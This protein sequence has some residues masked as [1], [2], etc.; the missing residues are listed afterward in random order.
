MAPGTRWPLA[1]V[2]DRA[3]LET[4]RPVFVANAAKDPA[5]RELAFFHDHGFQ[6]YAGVPRSDG[7]VAIMS[8]RPLA[9]SPQDLLL[10]ALHS[11]ALPGE[12]SAVL[13]PASGALT[14][15]F[16]LELTAAELAAGRQTGLLV[17]RSTRLGDV[18]RD[19]GEAVADR[20]LSQLCVL[21]RS[22][23]R[24]TAPVGRL[25]NDALG[26][27]LVDVSLRD[28]Q[29]A[30]ERLAREVRESSR[31][32]TA[33]GLAHGEGLAGGAEALADLGL[34]AAEESRATGARSVPTRLSTGSVP[35][36]V[37]PPSAGP[38]AD[39]ALAARYQRLALLNRMS[40]ELF[41][42]KPFA[43]ALTGACHTALALTGARSV[44]V[45]FADE[46][47]SPSLAY[48]HG[49][50]AFSEETSRAEERSL[51][52]EAFAE[53]RL[54]SRDAA[55]RHWSAAPLMRITP[56]AVSVT[57]AA[58]FGYDR[59]PSEDPER[60]RALVE[61]AR[62]LCN[63][64]LIQQTLQQ[65]KIFA[66][67]FEQ[68]ADALLI[69]DR[70]G[71]TQMWNRSAA[72]LF[73]WSRE[74][75][76]GRDSRS[77]IPPD[78]KE[79]SRKLEAELRDS[80]R[81]LGFETV[82]LRKDG[83]V[84]PVEIA[85]TALRDDDGVP[86]GSLI[87]HRDITNRK[88]LDRMK[89]EFMALVSHELRTPLTAIRGFAETIFD[90]WDEIT[91]EQRRHYL[92]IILDEADRLSKLVTDFLDITRLEGGGIEWES[93]EILVPEFFGKI[94]ELFKEHPSKAAV[95]AEVAPDA[96]RLKG[97]PEQLYRL[98]VNLV[99]NALK[100]S[101][102]GGTV[103]LGAAPDG[104]AVTLS[105]KDQGPGIAPADRERLFT[106][107]FRAGDQVARKTPGTGLGLAIC[108]SIVDAH[109]G[110][111]WA[112]SEPG[113]GAVFKARLPR[114]GK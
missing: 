22:K 93:K 71:R 4:G 2:F 78:R 85:A 42:D 19:K 99:G 32:P 61:I 91:I 34:Q 82:R 33:A 109:G 79:E 11:R 72:E 101:V 105:V 51:A 74:E 10:L 3:T 76:V 5:L 68:S 69:A 52:D 57:G 46:L 62:I 7:T 23:T 31:W 55:P 70:E 28:A 81:L 83:S 27:I 58:V 41:S 112:E 77:L 9:L 20:L 95:V 106:K 86:F 94:A 18:R 111:I 84:V 35:P 1:A 67:I 44:A 66:E 75:L 90:F 15:A 100:Y 60:D 43:A 47:G 103:T 108:K 63:A 25:T 87:A 30:A 21:L 54:V 107:F 8:E 65:Q 114:E 110:R 38:T 13:E 102:P 16:L 48:R 113:K 6:S 24:P 64:R 37:E 97:D 17:L 49:D 26:V 56:Q 92:R 36:P 104:D 29:R 59:A 89:S 50:G 96:E 39:T 12:D 45:Y 98:M 88:E 14:R 80:G 53:R 73:G 40:L